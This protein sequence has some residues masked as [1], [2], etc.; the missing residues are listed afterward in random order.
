[1]SEAQSI[2]S[3]MFAGWETYHWKLIG[4]IAPLSDEQLGLRAGPD[5]RT[6]EET[7]THM[8]GA[9]ARWFQIDADSEGFAEFARWDGPN[10]PL[11]SAQELV[12]GLD[13]TWRLMQKA[14]ASWTP[15]QWQERYPGEDPDDPPEITRQWILWH[16]LEH[17]LHHGGEVSLILGLHGL[18]T[19]DI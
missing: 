8:I 5:L 4:V 13:T 17:D 12:R 14:V 18:P 2:V 7:V 6:I 16:L 9:R 10:M 1:M 11:R 3:A 19:P 15:A